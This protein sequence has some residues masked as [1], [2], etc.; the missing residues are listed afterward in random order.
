[1]DV[2]SLNPSRVSQRE[3]LFL[4]PAEQ[5]SLFMEAKADT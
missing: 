4:S 2:L 1:M 5:S 3:T